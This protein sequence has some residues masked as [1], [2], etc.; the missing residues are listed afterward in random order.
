MVPII[1]SAKPTTFPQVNCSFKNNIPTKK[2]MAGAKLINGYAFVI[3][4][5]LIAPIQNRDAINADK[6]PENTKGSKINFI[7]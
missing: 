2:T 1:I 7:K 3:S 6:K 5:L 4:N